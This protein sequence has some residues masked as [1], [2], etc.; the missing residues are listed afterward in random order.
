MQYGTTKFSSL[1]DAYI[2]ENII[3]LGQAVKNSTFWSVWLW[4][5]QSLPCF[6]FFYLCCRET[7]ICLAQAVRTSILRKS[8]GENH[9]QYILSCFLLL[10]YLLMLKSLL[11][12]GAQTVQV[13]NFHSGSDW[14]KPPDVAFQ[15]QMCHNDIADI[16]KLLTQF[17]ASKFAITWLGHSKLLYIKVLPNAL[18]I[19]TNV[20]CDITSSGLRVIAKLTNFF[21]WV[22]FSYFRSLKYVK[23][24]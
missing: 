21:S 24:T 18:Y 4:Y 15:F 16:G 23:K 2:L 12:Y 20:S 22:F 9:L 3:R 6:L 17:L 19:A 10:S 7:F 1:F 11:V 5:Y 13:F 14:G 8:L